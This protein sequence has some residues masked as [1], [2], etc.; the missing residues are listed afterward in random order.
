MN[1]LPFAVE[2][3]GANNDYITDLAEDHKW[4]YPCLKTSDSHQLDHFYSQVDHLHKWNM[5]V[6]DA[7]CNF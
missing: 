5:P 2:K 4:K 1:N 6:Y 7:L 3:V